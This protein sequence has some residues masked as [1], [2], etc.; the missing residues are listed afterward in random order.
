MNPEL[1]FTLPP[2]QTASGVVDIMLHTF[3]R[4]FSA[5]GINEVTDRI[6]EAILRTVI[7]YGKVC[8]DDPTNYDARSEV[9]WAGSL[10]HNGL[11]GLGR[12]TDWACHQLEHELGGLFDVTHGAGLAA[13]WGAWARYVYQEDVMRFARFGVNVWG[14]NLNYENPEE[15][16]LAAIQATQDFFKSI[17][18]PITTTELLGRET[19]DEEM[20]EMALKCTYYEKSARSK[21]CWKT[22]FIRS[23]KT[24]DSP[25]TINS[26][27]PK[28]GGLCLLG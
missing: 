23:I 9:F 24:Q 1:L 19:T 15:T 16:A 26:R 28:T 2:W 3:E 17:S 7:Q 5:G 27:P 6:A 21:C 11:T 8:I 22:I 25:H 12:V 10:S 20:R 14:L 13:V 18:M 4:Y